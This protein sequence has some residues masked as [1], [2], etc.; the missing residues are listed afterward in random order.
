[1]NL[2]TSSAALSVSV[3]RNPLPVAWDG[4]AE[5]VEPG[6]VCYLSDGAVRRLA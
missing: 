4:F 2:R 6:D 1:M 5:L 3:R